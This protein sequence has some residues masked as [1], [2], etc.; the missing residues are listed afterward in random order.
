[1]SIHVEPPS[2][3]CTYPNAVLEMPHSECVNVLEVYFN[4]QWVCS[5][6]HMDHANTD[7][8]PLLVFDIFDCKIS[9]LFHYNGKTCNITSP[10]FY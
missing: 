1:M 6:I 8:K 7:S 2:V 3:L 9:L 5:F 10:L 4:H